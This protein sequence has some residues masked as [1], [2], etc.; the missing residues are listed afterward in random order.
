MNMTLGARDLFGYFG[1][2]ELFAVGPHV[3]VCVMLFFTRFDELCTYEIVCMVYKS[4]RRSA[5]IR[6]GVS[7]IWR[8]E[9]VN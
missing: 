4:V 9:P 3:E 2:Q 6:A 7:N 1:R 8:L 5:S